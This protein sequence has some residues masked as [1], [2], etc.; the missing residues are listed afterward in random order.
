MATIINRRKF[1][2]Q[3]AAV[4]IG[5]NL[6]WTACQKN[7]RT[8]QFFTNQ[9]ATVVDQMAAQ[10]VPSDEAPGSKEADV[11][12]FID[13]QLT[14]AYQR[15]QDDYRN[16]LKAVQETAIQLFGKKF[17]DL[18]QEQQVELML[19]LESNQAPDGI[20]KDP[21]APQFFRM[22][23]DHSLQ[24]FYGDPRHG[25]NKEYVSYKMLELKVFKY[26]Q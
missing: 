20:W 24:G 1:V 4:L 2:K 9:E 22:I 6:V 12:N 8:H 3:T 26:N 7:V 10:I 5:G 17:D 23:R 15:Y 18:N 14:Q 11:L 21:T 16:G 25:G 13:I 19:A